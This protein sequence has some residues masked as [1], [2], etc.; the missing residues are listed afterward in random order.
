MVAG[1][2]SNMIE[3]SWWRGSPNVFHVFAGERR[4][5]R[6]DRYGRDFLISHTWNLPIRWRLMSRTPGSLGSCARY[7]LGLAVSHLR[8]AIVSL[9]LSPGIAD[10]Y[11]SVR[12]PVQAV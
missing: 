1:S 2:A 4:S 7:L 9:E 6:A 5:T 10:I 3:R 11:C 8:F 12:L